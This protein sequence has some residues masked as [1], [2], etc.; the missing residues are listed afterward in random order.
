MK[1]HAG[2]GARHDLIAAKEGFIGPTFTFK[3][4]CRRALW[5]FVWVVFA[6]YSPPPLHKLRIAVLRL[7][8]ARVSYNAFVYPDVRI[9]APWNL[10]MDD[11]ATLAR[12]VICYNIASVTLSRKA[13]VSQYAHLCTGTHDY[14]DRSFPLLAHPIAIGP[15]AWVCANAFVG[16]GVRIGEGA[17]LSAAGVSTTD[18]ADWSIYRGN[19]AVLLKSRAPIDD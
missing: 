4:R 18:L 7:F 8:G 17:I 16:P 15:R 1:A 10:I 12:G 3:N 13:V 5:Q 11:Y 9:W 2:S 19:P 14:R 6:R